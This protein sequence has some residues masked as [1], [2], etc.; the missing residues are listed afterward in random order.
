MIRNVEIFPLQKRKK[1]KNCSTRN[2]LSLSTHA[3]KFPHPK[4]NNSLSNIF[5]GSYRITRGGDRDVSF[6]NL[7]RLGGEKNV[8]PSIF[9][10]LSFPLSLSFSLREER[11]TRK[12][13]ISFVSQRVFPLLPPAYFNIW[14][15]RNEAWRE[16]RWKHPLKGTLMRVLSTSRNRGPILCTHP[17]IVFAPMIERRLDDSIISRICDYLA[18]FPIPLDSVFGPVSWLKH[19]HILLRKGEFWKWIPSGKTHVAISIKDVTHAVLLSNV[20]SNN[21]VSIAT[22]FSFSSILEMFVVTDTRM[23]KYIHSAKS[24]LLFSL[25]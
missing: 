1:K 15:R 25:Q 21:T 14:T 7:F 13:K 5:T 18:C 19:V 9:R 6:A 20:A 4:I 10:P 11:V 8:P 17:C 22:Y 3:S 16:K 2:P 23:I 12:W 24:I